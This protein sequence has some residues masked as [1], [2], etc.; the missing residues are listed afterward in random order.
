MR[1]ETV[2]GVACLAAPTAVQDRRLNWISRFEIANDRE[3]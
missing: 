3:N 2:F 1:M